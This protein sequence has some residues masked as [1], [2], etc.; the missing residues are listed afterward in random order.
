MM[1]LMTANARLFGLP[2]PFH[3]FLNQIADLHILKRLRTSDNF[4][5]SEDQFHVSAARAAMEL[6]SLIALAYAPARDLEIAPTA[7]LIRAPL[8][9]TTSNAGRHVID[10]N[11][12]RLVSSAE[13][14]K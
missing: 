3:K 2:R 5:G 14:A 10:P 6:E 11:V 4:H 7:V 8:H 13:D 9:R 12:Y 1:T